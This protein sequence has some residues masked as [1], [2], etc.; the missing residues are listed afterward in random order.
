MPLNIRI[1]NETKASF[2]GNNKAGIA[3]I[4]FYN[5]LLNMAI[6]MPPKM[7]F[8]VIIPISIEIKAFSPDT[9]KSLND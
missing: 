4:L 5:C 9:T 6:R 1:S 8:F 2:T 3:K 7:N